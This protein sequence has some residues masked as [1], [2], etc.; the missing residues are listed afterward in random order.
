MQEA[1]LNYQ[2]IYEV[3]DLLK[4]NGNGNPNYYLVEDVDSVYAL[5]TIRDIITQRVFKESPH[6]IHRV[7]R[8]VG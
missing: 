6:F 1:K 4:D 8:K 2:P 7:T 3:G 5:I